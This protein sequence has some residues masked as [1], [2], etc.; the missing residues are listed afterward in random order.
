MRRH[1]G[2]KDVP[3]LK[4]SEQRKHRPDPVY[5]D[6]NLLVQRDEKVGTGISQRQVNLRLVHLLFGGFQLCMDPKTG[7]MEL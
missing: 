4:K 3:G 7:T 6:R 2:Q 5:I 1:L